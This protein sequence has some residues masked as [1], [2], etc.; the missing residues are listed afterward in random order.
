MDQF[1]LQF[2]IEEAMLY[3]QVSVLFF[4]LLAAATAMPPWSWDVVP[5]YFHC[6][7]VTGEWNDAALQ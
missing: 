5:T 1:I 2:I 4:C 6:A 3:L 7:N